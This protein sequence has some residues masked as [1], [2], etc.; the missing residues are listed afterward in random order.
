MIVFLVE[1]R[2][3]VT[4]RTIDGYRRFCDVIQLILLI[5]CGISDSVRESL[6]L[7]LLSPHS[8]GLVRLFRLRCRLV[9]VDPRQQQ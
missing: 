5:V 8:L 4:C 1:P 9:F 7:R 6:F 2:V 3:C